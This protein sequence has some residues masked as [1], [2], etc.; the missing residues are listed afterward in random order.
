[1]NENNKTVSDIKFTEDK[2]TAIESVV[3][4]AADEEL[5]DQAYQTIHEILVDAEKAVDGAMHKIGDYL[6]KA[7][8]DADIDKARRK[9]STHEESLNQLIKKMRG[10]SNHGKSKTYLYNAVNL[11]VQRN[12]IES[13][14]G[15]KVFHTYGNLPLSHKVVLLP[16]ENIKDKVDLINQIED[17]KLSVRALEQCKQKLIAQKT[18]NTLSSLLDSPGKLFTEEFKDTLSLDSI[19]KLPEEE[20]RAINSKIVEKKKGLKKVIKNIEKK[21]QSQKDSLKNYIELAKTID[22][23]FKSDEE[24]KS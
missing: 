16:V 12:D 8:Y 6:M 1:M 2:T 10:D 22:T 21:A 11:I 19:R 14:G 13:K 5:A 4:E 20:R 24:S 3:I 17:K 9:E 18:E 15:K 7:F 23:S